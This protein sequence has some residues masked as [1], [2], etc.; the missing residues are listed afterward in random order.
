MSKQGGCREARSFSSKPL[1]M[2]SQGAELSGPFKGQIEDFMLKIRI[3]SNS[4]TF[5]S[6]HLILP[7]DL[8]II[9]RRLTLSQI[10]WVDIRLK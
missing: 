8:T 9:F 1:L 6:K 4:K 10:S 5:K 3:L 2:G 7:F